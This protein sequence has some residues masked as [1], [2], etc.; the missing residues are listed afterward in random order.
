[1]YVC[2]ECTPGLCTILTLSPGR[3]L[4]YSFQDLFLAFA[5]DSVFIPL[6]LIQP[7]YGCGLPPIDCQALSLHI[8][9]RPDALRR[10]RSRFSPRSNNP[11]ADTWGHRLSGSG[12][13][14]RLP[15]YR[16]QAGCT[17]CPLRGPYSATLVGG[18]A[19]SSPVPHTPS[20]ALAQL[21]GFAYKGPLS[22]HSPRL[23]LCVNEHTHGWRAVAHRASTPGAAFARPLVAHSPIER[24]PVFSQVSVHCRVCAAS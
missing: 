3:S 21:E 5:T 20:S 18:R 2:S 4:A 15:T 6:Y 19:S 10:S 12:R 9:S 24:P 22:S 23:Q 16:S 13:I 11:P 17:V 7:L 14:H 1:M 8:A